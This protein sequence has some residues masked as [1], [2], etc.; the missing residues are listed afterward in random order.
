M[1]QFVDAASSGT[2][3][4]KAQAV[5]GQHPKGALQGRPEGAA[6]CRRQR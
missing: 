2:L 4:V 1:Q 5:R 6:G 3:P